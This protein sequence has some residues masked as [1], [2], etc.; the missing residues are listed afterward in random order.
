MQAAS[1]AFKVVSRIADKSPPGR[2]VFC[3]SDRRRAGIRSSDCASA[4]PATIS[5]KANTA[6][7]RVAKPIIKIPPQI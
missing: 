2:S 3:D 6:M 5:H 7:P 1:Q 4:V